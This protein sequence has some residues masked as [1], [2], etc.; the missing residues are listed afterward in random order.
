MP[1]NIRVE[2]FE[3]PFDLLLHLIKKNEMD[4]YDIKIYEITKQYMEYLDKM[5]DMDLEITSEFIVT[6]ATLIEIKSK[7]L[8]P[9]SKDEISVEK[10]DDPRNELISK[11]LEYKKFKE[12]SIF[13]KEHE[14]GMVF[15][16]KPEII[17]DKDFDSKDLFKDITMLNLYNL[18][19]ELMDRYT[20]KINKENRMEKI[21]TAELYKI[22][23]KMLLIKEEF[24]K[25]NRFSFSSIIKTCNSKIEVIVTFLAILELIKLRD[26]QVIQEDNFK[27]IIIERIETHEES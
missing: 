18:Y 9:K 8:L 26:I 14:L 27:E 4:I 16:K 21:L 2:N 13:L 6:A 19:N 24:E 5:K 25:R 15:G 3:G 1:V 12:A 11:L 17:I 23:D 20:S 10:E 22:E 7:M